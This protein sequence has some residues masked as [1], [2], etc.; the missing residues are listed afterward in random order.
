MDFE[1]LINIL[2]EINSKEGHL[3]V[4]ST[5]LSNG[6]LETLKI[7]ENC[8][9]CKDDRGKY[10]LDKFHESINEIENFLV[11]LEEKKEE[12]KKDDRRLIDKLLNRKKEQGKES[13]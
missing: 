5:N 1:K 8:T 6:L 10:N 9:S 2:N 3:M 12:R 11:E 13:I 7:I 4:R